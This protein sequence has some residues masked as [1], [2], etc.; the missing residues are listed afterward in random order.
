[1][2]KIFFVSFADKKVLK[3]VNL[4]TDPKPLLE[5]V[6]EPGEPYEG[7]SLEEAKEYLGAYFHEALN[8]W[9]LEELM[10]TIQDPQASLSN[11]DYAYQVVYNFRVSGQ[12]AS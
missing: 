9:S 4:P 10:A 7:M 3:Q 2:A 6:R 12:Q 8:V 11:C 5:V 1:M